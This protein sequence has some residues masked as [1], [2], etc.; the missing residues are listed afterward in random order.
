MKTERKD[1]DGVSLHQVQDAETQRFLQNVLCYYC[2]SKEHE[3]FFKL[4]AAQPVSIERKD[5]RTLR[6]KPYVAC[7]KSDGVRLLLMMAR[8]TPPGFNE[9]IKL[10]CVINRKGDIFLAPLAKVPNAM[11]QGTVL[12]GELTVH[13]QT[14]EPVFIVFDCPRLSGILITDQTVTQRLRLVRLVL[15]EEGYQSTFPHDP[16]SIKM[17]KMIPKREFH[18]LEGIVH[19]QQME[20]KIDGTIFT[21]DEPGWV[22]GRHFGLF[23]LKPPGHHTVDFLIMNDG[24]SISVFDPDQ[25][26]QIVVG[27]LMDHSPPGCIGECSYV[28]DGLWNLISIR[29]DKAQSNDML[30]YKKTLLNIEENL[31]LGEIVEACL[32]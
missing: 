3:S 23:K 14:G 12:D 5:F 9:P 11:W 31:S 21:P 24:I 29:H 28:S 8:L 1:L 22:V 4:P 15:D 2:C 17:K 26:G 10:C 13:K 20:Y 18:L 19:H 7:E 32:H 25:C 27:K 16:F 30:T 6:S